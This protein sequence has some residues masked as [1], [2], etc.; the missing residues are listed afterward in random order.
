ME[1]G[2]KEWKVFWKVLEQAREY[3]NDRDKLSDLLHDVYVKAGNLRI[4]NTRMS[5]LLEKVELF[6][7]MIRAYVKGEYKEY[8]LR[9]II[10]IV[11]GL[12]YFLNPFDIVPDFFP[13]AGY[14][15]DLSIIIWIISSIERDIEAFEEF[16]R[17]RVINI[18]S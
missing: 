5:V 7:Q 4:G 12:L 15:D 2:S 18:D 16:R 13:V 9:T 17:T 3:I 1:E 6:S 8:P 14:L 11:A 10:L